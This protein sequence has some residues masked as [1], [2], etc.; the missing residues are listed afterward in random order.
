M[1]NDNPKYPVIFFY[2]RDK[3][4]KIDNSSYNEEYNNNLNN[5]ENLLNENNN[6]NKNIMN[7]KIILII[8]I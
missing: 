3:N 1:E 5:E 2:Q 4:E 8:L 7:Q 6:F